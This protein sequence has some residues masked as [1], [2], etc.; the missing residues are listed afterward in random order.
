[1]PSY[2]NIDKYLDQIHKD[3]TLVLGLVVGSHQDVKPGVRIPKADAQSSPELH[4]PKSYLS[5]STTNDTYLMI[6]IDID[7]PFP[8]WRG[9]GP[10]L[11]WVQPNLKPDPVTGRLSPPGPESYIV[12]YIGPAPPPPSSPHRYCFFLYRQPEGLDVDKY[13]AKRGG[14][15]VGNVA[16]MWFD[17]EKHERELG[18]KG[19]I[20]AGNYF[21]S[22]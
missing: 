11:H 15:K 22:N 5:S 6:A 2:K 20:V 14:K 21:V 1:M 3:K 8:S 16:R 13:I 9:L 4:L 10:I 12:N 7:A 18:L 17:L 19:G